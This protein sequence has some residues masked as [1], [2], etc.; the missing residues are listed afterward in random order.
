MRG[1]I[2]A[3]FLGLNGPYLL[4]PPGPRLVP[5]EPQLL[6]PSLQ[7]SQPGSSS[8]V[9]SS[10]LPEGV[11]FLRARSATPSS[12]TRAPA[13]LWA[14][15]L[16]PG[17]CPTDGNPSTGTAQPAG[18]SISEAAAPLPPLPGGW[19]QLRSLSM[20]LDRPAGDP[21]EALPQPHDR[22]QLPAFGGPATGSDVF[23]A[24]PL[25]SQTS[26]PPMQRHEAGVG[27]QPSALL[28]ARSSGSGAPVFGGAFHGGGLGPAPL[29]TLT[30]LQS[31]L[32]GAGQTDPAFEKLL[33]GTSPRQQWLF[34]IAP[35][36]S[37]SALPMLNEDSC[38]PAV[39]DLD[40]ITEGGV[41][42]GLPGA[43]GSAA[44]R[45]LRGRRM[46]SAS[47]PTSSRLG[48]EA[49]AARQ[50]VAVAAGDIGAYPGLY[51]K[52][53]PVEVQLANLPRVSVYGL[54]NH[55]SLAIPRIAC[56]PPTLSGICLCSTWGPPCG[57][58]VNPAGLAAA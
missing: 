22:S 10:P 50:R 20:D 53:T 52:H 55:P 25:F 57:T 29:D 45:R 48:G 6:P 46:R 2:C 31:G 43:G 14:A 49:R 40:A 11:V 30:G 8:P 38:V 39:D 47:V 33:A 51:C 27:G 7:Q 28:G 37:C 44:A 26:L 32:C 34:G 23:T 42:D 18:A 16:L 12:G 13:C 3:G 35:V 1:S 9:I 19:P 17:P 36:G 54:H 56:C 5:C 58:L 4:S 24:P 21:S 15:G 41:S